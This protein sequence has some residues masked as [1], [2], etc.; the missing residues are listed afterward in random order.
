MTTGTDRPVF[1]QPAAN[2]A[3][4]SSWLTRPRPSDTPPRVVADDPRPTVDED[5]AAAG[6]ENGARPETQEQPAVQPEG[7]QSKRRKARTADKPAVVKLPAGGRKTTNFDLPESLA[8]W[9]KATASDRRVG[10]ADILIDAL[11]AH[12]GEIAERIARRPTIGGKRF[13]ART[14]RVTTIADPAAEPKR[15][16]TMRFRLDDWDTLADLETE[17]GAESMVQMVRTALTVYM[18][19]RLEGESR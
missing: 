6:G 17:M 18:E 4:A 12:D 5:S 8:Q 7:K 2:V 9:V 3:E 10:M 19:H 13:A 11:E 14:V 16:V 1:E 15:T